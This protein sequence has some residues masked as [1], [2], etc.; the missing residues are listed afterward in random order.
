MGL[1]GIIDYIFML[2]LRYSVRV[3]QSVGFAG[4]LV[5]ETKIWLYIHDIY[6]HT[7]NLYEN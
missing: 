1:I 7:T 2:L 6:S 3:D 5:I 4:K